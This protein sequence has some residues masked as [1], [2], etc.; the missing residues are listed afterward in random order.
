MEPVLRTAILV[1]L[2]GAIPLGLAILSSILRPVPATLSHPVSR[3]A[4]LGPGAGH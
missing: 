4:R 1:S 3:D 2:P